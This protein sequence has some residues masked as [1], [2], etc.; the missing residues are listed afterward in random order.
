MK[1]FALAL[2]CIGVLLGVL[3]LAINPEQ[4]AIYENPMTALG[5]GLI[6]LGMVMEAR[7][8]VKKPA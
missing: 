8:Q 5:L 3:Y 6:G 2:P 4:G 1:T 7:K